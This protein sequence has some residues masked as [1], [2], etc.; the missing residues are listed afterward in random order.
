MQLSDIKDIN[1]LLDSSNDDMKFTT[2]DSN[3]IITLLFGMSGAGKSTLASIHAGLPVM[4]KKAPKSC[5]A[6]L[7]CENAHSGCTSVT[8]KPNILFDSTNHLIY[9]D[10]PGFED[11]DGPKQEII[12][13]F[14]IYN[15]LDSI[16]KNKNKIKILLV[17]SSSEIQADRAKLAKL[18]FE[19]VEKIFPNKEQLQKAVGI[20]ITKSDPEYEGIDYINDFL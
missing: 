6:I 1:K 10:C 19:R 13:S 8:R 18:I 15:L 17:V 3:D 14:Y 5:G 7:E 16:S 9:A 12:N 4:V 2:G 11:S 20:V